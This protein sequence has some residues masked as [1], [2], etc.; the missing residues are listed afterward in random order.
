MKFWNS[1]NKRPTLYL[2]RVRYSPQNY[3]AWIRL[4]P[5]TAAAVAWADHQ[6]PSAEDIKVTPLRAPRELAVMPYR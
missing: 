1:I 2:V 5:D 3:R 6:W 4:F